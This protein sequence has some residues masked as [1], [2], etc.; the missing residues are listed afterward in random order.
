MNAFIPFSLSR[1]GLLAAA[2]AALLLGPGAALGAEPEQN[3]TREAA[4]TELPT[5]V[6]TAQKREENVQKIPMSLTV[7]TDDELNDSGVRDT[8]ELMRYIPNAFV[9]DAGNYH[10]TS[11]RGVGGFITSLHSPVGLYVDDV[12]LPNVF[13]QNP[14]LFDVERVEVLK[15]PQGA[16]YGRN[17]ESGVINIVTRQPDNELRGRISTEYNAYDTDHGLSSGAKLGAAASGPLKEDTLYLG[18]AGKWDYTG[19]YVTNAYNDDDKATSF[20]DFTGRGTL[21]WTPDSRWDVSIIMDGSANDDGMGYGRYLDGPGQTSPGTI[22]SDEDGTRQRRANGQ[23]LRVKYADDAV[24]FTSVTGRRFFDD[25][26]G[27]DMDMTPASVMVGEYDSTNQLLSQEF[28][29]A[30]A[31]DTGPLEWLTGVYAYKE[32]LDVKSVYNYP[33]FFGAQ[34]R[35]TDIDIQGGALFGQAT[36]TLFDRLHLTGGLRYDYIDMHADQTYDS[37]LFG[38]THA[39]YGAGSNGAEILPKASVSYDLSDTVMPYATVSRGYLAGGFDYTS[40]TSAATLQYDPEYTLNYEVGAKTTWLDNRLAVNV[41]LF[42]IAM[43]DKQVAEAVPATGSV[44][45]SNAAEAH[46]QG[47]EVEVRA[48]PAQGWELFGSFGYTDT[49]VDTWSGV[50][51]AGPYDY[52]GNDLTYAPEYTYTVG[53]QYMHDSGFFGRMELLGTGP[54]YHDAANTLREDGYE[55]VNTRIGYADETYEVTLWCKNIFDTEYNT[56]QYAISGVPAGFDGASRQFGI[57]L[58]YKF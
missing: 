55:L 12:N 44:Y 21:R 2:L 37:T 16:L 54:M 39:E 53:A 24:A 18:L 19:G 52:S 15:G 1:H 57:T 38:L 33:T 32:D 43:D 48:R 17:S 34:S 47:V 36:Y 8:S 13:M 7:V 25:E 5:V 40:P 9:R 46:S 10:Q 58:T 31:P 3:A 20:N 51:V 50:N 11:I 30:S 23:T 28:R 26:Y 27:I 22:D 35:D 42:Y 56:V 45:I 14:E 49:E 6:V 29:L 4:A 41:A